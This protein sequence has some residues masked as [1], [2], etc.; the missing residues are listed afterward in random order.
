M[1]CRS[2]TSVHRVLARAASARRWIGAAGLVGLLVAIN[3]VA[4]PE[5]SLSSR[6]TAASAGQCIQHRPTV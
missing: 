4:V 6:P 2:I 3:N 1:T 5:P